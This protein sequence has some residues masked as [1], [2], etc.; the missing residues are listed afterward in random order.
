MPMMCSGVGQSRG[1]TGGVNYI[2][3]MGSEADFNAGTSLIRYEEVERDKQR[4]KPLDRY[5]K[6][7]NRLSYRRRERQSATSK[8]IIPRRM[9]NDF[10]YRSKQ[11]MMSRRYHIKASTFAVIGIKMNSGTGHDRL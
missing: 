6:A 3:Y 2:L 7:R 10:P 9:H 1:E 4:S 5:Y 8:Y 11:P